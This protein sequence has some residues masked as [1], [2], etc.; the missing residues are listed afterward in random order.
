MNTFAEKLDAILTDSSFLASINALKNISA[1]SFRALTESEIKQLREQGNR[2]HE[3]ERV[4]VVEEFTTEAVFNSSFAGEC[5][6]G[7]FDKVDVTIRASISHR[8]GIYN[9]TVINSFIGDNCLILDAGVIANYRIGC[10]SVISRV[11]E[12]SASGSRGFGNGCVITIGNETGGREIA[13]FAEMNIP[14]AE[15]VLKNRS[16]SELQR[17]YSDFI[18]DYVSRCTLPFGIVEAGARINSASIIRDSFI[19]SSVS[20]DGATLVENCTVLGAPGEETAISHGAIVRNSCLQWGCEVTSM[21]IVENSILTEHSHVERHGKATHSIIGPNSGIAEGE[22]TSSLIGPFVGFHHQSMLIAAVWPEGKGNIGYGANIGS[23]HT[24]RAPDQEIWC[25]EGLFFGLGANV[26]FPA[27]YV[28]SP[29]SI[30]ATAVVTLPQKLEFP[31]SLIAKPENRPQ[32]IPETFNE[33]F[34]DGCLPTTFTPFYETRGNTKK[35][36]RPGERN[37]ILKYSVRILS[38]K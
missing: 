28:N 36:T 31:F 14:I 30:I 20:I 1:S 5:L 35:G 7:C 17:K 9:S 25:G 12:L 24:S 8:A 29:Y 3:W 15:T 13:S 38:L 32:G 27:N 33:L 6:I 4:R 10:G 21:A 16:D 19:G 11:M 34:P 18:E 22:V 26:K 37:S 2:S 23:N